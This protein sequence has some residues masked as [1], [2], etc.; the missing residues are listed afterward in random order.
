MSSNASSPTESP[1]VASHVPERKRNPFVARELAEAEETSRAED[2]YCGTV[3]PFDYASCAIHRT[4]LPT[5]AKVNALHRSWFDKGIRL[6]VA[7]DA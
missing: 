4:G 3:K 5:R 2:V 6:A 1:P 7:L